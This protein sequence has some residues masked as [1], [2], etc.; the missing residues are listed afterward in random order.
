MKDP[1]LY[2]QVE[3]ALKQIMGPDGEGLEK[4][5]ADLTKRYI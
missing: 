5:I 1:E 2:R 3:V 4:V